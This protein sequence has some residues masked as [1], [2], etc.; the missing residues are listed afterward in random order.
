MAHAELLSPS[1]PMPELNRNRRRQAEGRHRIPN[2]MQQ[3]DSSCV[4]LPICIRPRKDTHDM[5]LPHTPYRQSITFVCLP[6][7]VLHPVPSSLLCTDS[8][9][10]A[11]KG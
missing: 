9:G 5:T 7:P 10:L 1:I 6:P 3:P 2:H 8:C 4:L 11:H